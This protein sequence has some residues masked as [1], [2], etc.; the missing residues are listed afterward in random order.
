M[1]HLHTIVWPLLVAQPLYAGN[2]STSDLALASAKSD[3]ERNKRTPHEPT[4]IFFPSRPTGRYT[5]SL[6]G[7]SPWLSKWN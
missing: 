6:Y 4:N 2:E 7:I 5:K 3:V 1:P